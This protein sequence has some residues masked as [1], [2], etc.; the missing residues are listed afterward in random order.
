MDNFHI[1]PLLLCVLLLLFLLLPMS[2]A[3]AAN[4]TACSDAGVIIGLERRATGP[5]VKEWVHARG[6]D[7]IAVPGDGHGL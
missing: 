1:I 7:V 5:L 2:D 3:A 6:F 4:R